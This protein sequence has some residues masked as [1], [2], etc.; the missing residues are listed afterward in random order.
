MIGIGFA[1]VILC[2]ILAMPHLFRSRRLTPLSE[3]VINA[4]IVGL[5]LNEFD[6][7]F[8]KFPNSSTAASVKSATGTTLTL[9][10]RT[11]NDLFSQLFG[12]GMVECEAQFYAKAVSARKTDGI[13]TTDATMLEHGEC[14]FAYISGLDSKCHPDTPLVFGPVIPGTTTLDRSLCYGK[15]VILKIDN[16]VASLPINS[17]GK[18]IYNGLDLLDP[19]Q[20]FWHGKAPD[21]KWPK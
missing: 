8:G 17:A 6:S 1:T 20:P 12:A 3:A 4:R 11:S 19:R 14:S 7:K 2:L 15:A 21:V 13:F 10:D 16:S 18:I 5:F 9:A